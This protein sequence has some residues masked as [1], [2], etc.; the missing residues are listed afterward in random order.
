MVHLMMC[1][2]NFHL[3]A[4]FNRVVLELT[5][6]RSPTC[7]FGLIEHGSIYRKYDCERSMSF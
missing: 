3:L 5:Y 7:G 6:L 1:Y 4:G 2:E